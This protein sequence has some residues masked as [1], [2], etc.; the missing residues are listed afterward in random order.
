MVTSDARDFS[1]TF[2][3]SCWTSVVLSYVVRL[4]ASAEWRRGEGDPLC[5]VLHEVQNLCVQVW[6]KT[7][8][9]LKSNSTGQDSIYHESHQGLYESPVKKAAIQ[10]TPHDVIVVWLTSALLLE[11]SFTCSQLFPRCLFQIH[12]SSDGIIVPFKEGLFYFSSKPPQEME[13]SQHSTGIRVVCTGSAS[14]G[15]QIQAAIW[16]D[17]TVWY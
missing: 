8:P 9:R 2:I 12:H 5:Y 6:P 17:T 13:L 1:G 3:Q 10:D 15:L 4:H 16:F 11:W 14:A 7:W